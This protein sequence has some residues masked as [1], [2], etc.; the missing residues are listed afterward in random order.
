MFRKTQIFA[1]RGANRVAAENTR[2]AFDLAL[3]DDID[4]METDVQLSRNG[5]AVLW[6]D[7]TLARLGLPDRHI[8]DF[9]YAELQTMNFATLFDAAA[10]FES[11]MRLQDFIQRYRSRT[12]LLLEIKNRSAEA[13]A[14]I[15]L[16][17][18]Q[19]LA[20]AEK[21]DG[22]N[23]LIN[24][25]ELASLV[26]AH[27]CVPDFPLVYNMEPE[28]TITDVRAALTAQTFLHGYCLHISS[29]NSE[30]TALLRSHN[31]S[32]SAYTCNTDAEIKK[33][34]DLGVDILISDVP[35][36]ALQLRDHPSVTD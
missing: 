8:D 23:I 18:E 28:H 5:V 16:K 27:Q 26:Y 25:F 1:H 21:S 24:S 22:K 31:K 3:K 34:L 17:V 19:T 11:V 9:N 14:R 35:Q 4:G 36:K 33:A 10:P 15:R 6:H 29:L 13:P 12:R 20:L 32:I 2:T 30:I 7:D